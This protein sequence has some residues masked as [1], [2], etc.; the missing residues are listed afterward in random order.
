MNL[1]RCRCCGK[2]IPSHYYANALFC[3]DLCRKRHWD[4]TKRPSAN[5]SALKLLKGVV[6]FRPEKIVNNLEPEV[7][8]IRVYKY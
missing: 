7:T 6:G 1:S 3:S 8:W 2:K 5:K 4:I